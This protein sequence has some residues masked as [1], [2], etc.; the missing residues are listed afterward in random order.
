MS[1]KI[2]INGSRGRMGQAVAAAVKE[3]GLAIAAE[4]DV[5]DDLRAGMSQADAVIDFSSPPRHPRSYGMPWSFVSP[6]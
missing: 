4:T 5:G 1:L 2:H 3:A 6:W